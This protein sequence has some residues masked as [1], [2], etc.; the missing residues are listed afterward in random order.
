MAALVA[1]SPHGTLPTGRVRIRIPRPAPRITIALV[2]LALTVVIVE[3]RVPLAHA[4]HA[5]CTWGEPSNH[6]CGEALVRLGYP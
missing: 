5:A 1:T 3:A 6:S 2:V 4:A